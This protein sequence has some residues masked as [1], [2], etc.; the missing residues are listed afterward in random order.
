MGQVMQWKMN[1]CLRP[2]LEKHEQKTVRK[3]KRDKA[4]DG[5][6]TVKQQADVKSQNRPEKQI[7]VSTYLC[8]QTPSSAPRPRC[9]PSSVAGPCI[10]CKDPGGGAVAATLTARPRCSHTAGCWSAGG[11]G[12]RRGGGRRGDGEYMAITGGRNRLGGGGGCKYRSINQLNKRARMRGFLPLGVV[13][14]R[15][16]S[17]RRRHLQGPE[18]RHVVETGHRQSADVVVVEGAEERKKS[19]THNVI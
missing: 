8:R 13:I 16:P 10:A 6:A 15:L 5:F 7:C 2:H 1:T 9:A 18:L 3:S 19:R 14:C 17:A 4:K 11:W 12:R